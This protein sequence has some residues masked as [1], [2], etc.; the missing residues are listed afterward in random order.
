V[1]M[2]KT[3]EKLIPV[4]RDEKKL[5][6][7]AWMLV[8]FAFFGGSAIFFAYKK[9]EHKS[10]QDDRPAYVGQLFQN[11]RVIRQDG[12]E[13][14]LDDLKGNVWIMGA[15]SVTQPETC[16]RTMAVMKSLSET[17]NDRNDVIL[18]CM[19]I[20][21]GPAENVVAALSSESTKQGATLPQWWFATADPVTLHKYMKDK[22]KLN[23]LAH[24]ENGAWVYDTSLTLI[25]RDM[26]VRR[27]VVPQKRG[28][29]QFVTPFDF[30]QSAAW[31]EK[32]VKTGTERTNVDELK[33]LLEKTIGHLLSETTPAKS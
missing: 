15:V 12:R 24:L 31:D 16:A 13:S 10:F 6:R 30:D 14:G 22:F 5:R 4:E 26:K 7:T 32:G 2:G 23:D 3:V 8:A 21:P 17:Y 28:G 19:V 11:L 9:Y 27:A 20:D 1:P 25:D 18:V 29:P 33:F